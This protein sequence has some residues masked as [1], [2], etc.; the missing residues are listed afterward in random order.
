MSDF[1]YHRQ[2]KIDGRNAFILV[3]PV[4]AAHWK[5]AIWLKDAQEERCKIEMEG[6]LI[7]TIEPTCLATFEN[8]SEETAKAALENTNFKMLLKGE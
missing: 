8:I 1:K 3:P 7:V 2:F 4:G 5:S 6:G